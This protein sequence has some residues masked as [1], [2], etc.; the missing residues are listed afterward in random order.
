MIAPT[1]I[2]HSCC[3]RKVGEKQNNFHVILLFEIIEQ[4]T[5]VNMTRLD[6]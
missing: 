3:G 5:S 1:D 4:D 6:T 2:I